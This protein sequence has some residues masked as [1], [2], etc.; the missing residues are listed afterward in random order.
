MK[1]FISC[2]YCKSKVEHYEG[3]P[4]LFSTFINFYCLKKNNKFLGNMTSKTDEKETL[5]CFQEYKK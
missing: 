2:Q 1:K 3:A 5:S 4:K